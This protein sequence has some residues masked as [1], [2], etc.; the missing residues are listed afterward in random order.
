VEAEDSSEDISADVA[1]TP[2]WIVAAERLPPE[3]GWAASA[4]ADSYVVD[5]NGR[6]DRCARCH[7]AAEWAPGPEDIPESCLTCKFDVDQP[8]P[9]I[10][11][12]EWGHISCKICHRMDDDEVEP[13]FAW[14]DIAVIDEY[15]DL[16][17]T[18][19]LCRKCHEMADIADHKPAIN[20][21]DEH[22][23]LECTE[24]HDAHAKTVTCANSDCHEDVLINADAVTGHDEEHASVS[25][26]ACHDSAGLEV[27]PYEDSEMWVTFT[28]LML[29]GEESLVPHS[30]HSVQTQVECE[31][32]HFGANPWGLSEDVATGS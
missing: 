19:D 2:S 15:I 25:C 18:T 5:A 21:A 27:G 14:L 26:T 31:R 20:L 10:A 17:S 6:N 8:T 11:E 24:C 13:E 22:A 16:D 4:H 9:L 12:E 7:S 32:C 30:S 23:E 1:E 3:D 28:S 29:D